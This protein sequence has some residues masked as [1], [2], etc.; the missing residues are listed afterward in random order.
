MLQ[1]IPAKN[2]YGIDPPQY[3]CLQKGHPLKWKSA[4]GTCA[5]CKK[6]GCRSRYQCVECQEIY[7]L[8]CMTPPLYG[9]ICGA[10]H[11]Y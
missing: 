8:K 2:S 1:A 10:G 5:S 7:C 4:S 3:F 9:L 11:E 6:Q